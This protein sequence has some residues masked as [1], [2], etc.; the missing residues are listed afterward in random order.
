MSLISWMYNTSLSQ[1]L[2]IFDRSIDM[3]PKAQLLKDR[4]QNIINEQTY[5]VYRYINRGIFERDKVT[6]KL[7]VTLK[8]MIKEEKLLSHDVSMFLKA[9][10]GIDDRNKPFSWMDQ[11]TWLN[12]KALSK[13]RF[14]KEPTFFFKELP[15]RITRNEQ[16]WRRWIDENEPENAPV[17]DYQ[18]KIFADQNIGMFIHLCLIRA[19]RED[20][21]VLSSTKFIQEILGEAFVQ[22]VTDPIE[23]LFLETQTNLPVLYLLSAGADPTSNI[24]EFA[25][26]KKKYPTEKVS[27][28]EEQ[29]KIALEKIK[30]GFVNGDWVIL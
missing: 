30:Y 8:I 9:G 20:R 15:D 21:A 11:K 13:H 25:K 2:V 16:A 23:D 10:A 12:L 24:D 17:P 4:V 27:M 19:F 28:G 14:A 7:M 6:F 1:F 18:E 5:R 22:P 29:E 26:K 3:A